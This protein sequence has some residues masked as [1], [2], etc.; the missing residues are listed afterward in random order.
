MY[1]IV[2]IV[3]YENY[4]CIEKNGVS[5]S[6]NRKCLEVFVGVS[7]FLDF[8]VRKCFLSFCVMV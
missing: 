7:L 2:I 5:N 1:K 4:G 6:N 3:Y 8:D